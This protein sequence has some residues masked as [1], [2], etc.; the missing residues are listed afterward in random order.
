M[1]IKNIFL[2]FQV[3]SFILV[4]LLILPPA[5]TGCDTLQKLISSPDETSTTNISDVSENTADISGAPVLS[6]NPETSEHDLAAPFGTG[7]EENSEKSSDDSTLNHEN[8]T[9]SEQ[10]STNNFPESTFGTE[11]SPTL[12]PPYTETD[13][14]SVFDKMANAGAST[15]GMT[16]HVNPELRAKEHFVLPVINTADAEGYAANTNDLGRITLIE[17]IEVPAQEAGQLIELHVHEGDS[18]KYGATLAKIDD[19]QAKMAVTVSEAKLRTAE[20]KAGNDVN[21]RYAQAAKAVSEAELEQAFEANAKVPNTVTRAELN[22]LGLAVT[23]ATLQIEQA[24]HDLEVAKEEVEIQKAELAASKLTL[25]RRTI[26]APQD[27]IV[28][29][30]YRHLGEWVKPGD[31]ILRLIR[32]DVVRIKFTLDV[33]SVPMATVRGRNVEVKVHTLPNRVFQGR[34]TF[35]NPVLESGTRY[36][37][38]AEIQNE[39]EDGFWL[40]NSGMH[41]TAEIK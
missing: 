6:D 15:Y 33:E 11:N 19:D 21:V 37:V 38:W 26:S 14:H 12:L 31:P 25:R 20:Q 8:I 5:F 27:G 36:Q 28:V 29:E 23:Q 34:V 30:R 10:L 3:K 32:M 35:V 2:P 39:Q 7:T 17:E 18:V 16:G 9:P 24:R 1:S 4:L 41:A 40:L 13:N 22:R